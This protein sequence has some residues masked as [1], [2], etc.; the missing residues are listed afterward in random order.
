MSESGAVTTDYVVL[1]AAVVGTGI[2]V[3]SPT[4]NGVANLA[5]DIDDSLRGNIVNTSF[6]QA[7]YFDDFENG[8]GFWVGGE[9]DESDDYYGGI[10]GPYGGTNGAEV[11][12]RTY[13]LQ[14]G[15]DYAVIE[16]D[17]HAF[18]SWDNEQLITF[19]DGTPVTA[20]Q[21]NWQY[22]GVT[23]TWN[24]T[25]ANYT[26][27]VASSGTRAGNGYSPDWSDQ[28]ATVT[29]VV[30]DPGPSMT[31]GFGSTLDQ[32]VGDESWGIDNVNITSTNDPGGSV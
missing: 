8:S 10:L 31:V 27:S 29:I 18:D 4:S 5:G 15:Y 25:D 9:T 28:S 12:T 11:V 3:T 6:A 16:F 2:A 13:D 1:S 17:M 26:I 20:S 32:S 23:G 21:F 30:A 14:S 24:T 22:D 7:S 19:V